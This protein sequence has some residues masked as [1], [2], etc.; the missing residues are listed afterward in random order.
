MNEQQRN[1]LYG[2]LQ[3]EKRQLIHRLRQNDHYGLENAMSASVGELSGY[4][5]HPADLGTEMYE[6]G[7]DLALNDADER[8]LQDIEAALKRMESGEYG[9]CRVCGKEIPFERLEAVPTAE[10]CVEHQPD[11][12]SSIRR[13]VEESV[14]SYGLYFLDNRDYNAYDAEDAWQEVEQYGTSNPPD[15]FA[16]ARSYNELTIDHNEQRGYIDLVE[17]FSITDQEGHSDEITEITH[18]QAYRQKDQEESLEE[19]DTDFT[20]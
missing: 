13:P 3:E 19:T 15:Y 10:Y 16:E 12:H 2:Q 8:H 1:Q 11:Q 14:T 5:N 20:G 7:K 17:G 18:N 4:D 9:I 6:R